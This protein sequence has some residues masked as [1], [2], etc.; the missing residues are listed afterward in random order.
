MNLLQD[1]LDLALIEN[2]AF[3][4][5]NRYF[6]LIEAINLAFS[7]LQPY[8]DLKSVKLVFQQLPKDQLSY[9]K[10]IFSDEHRVI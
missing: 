6:S 8:A 4:L 3:S 10:Q 2:N 9:F 1:L 7:T 5:N